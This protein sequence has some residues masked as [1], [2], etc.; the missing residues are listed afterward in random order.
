VYAIT[1]FPQIV[2]L[3]WFRLSVFRQFPVFY[4]FSI[5]SIFKHFIRLSNCILPGCWMLDSDWL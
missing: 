4:W 2:C 1:I 3:C 5:V